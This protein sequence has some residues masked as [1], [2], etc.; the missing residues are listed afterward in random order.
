MPAQDLGVAVAPVYR[1]EEERR[2]ERSRR[3]MKGKK[4]SRMDML[5]RQILAM[6]EELEE[7]EQL[8]EE[9]E[10]QEVVALDTKVKVKERPVLERPTKEVDFGLIQEV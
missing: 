7:V 2:K 3:K 10:E 4:R 6:Q 5:A 9:E 8:V 1:P